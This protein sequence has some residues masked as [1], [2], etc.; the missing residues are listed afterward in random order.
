VKRSVANLHVKSGSVNVHRSEV[1]ERINFSNLERS[2]CRLFTMS[3][4]DERQRIFEIMSCCESSPVSIE[5]LTELSRKPSGF[6]TNKIRSK[7]WPKLL[8]INRYEIVDYKK[9]I[10]PHR[11]ERQ[12]R[13][14]I[15]RSFWS[16][17]CARHWGEKRLNRKRA[18]LSN[19]IIALLSNN[20][21]YYYFQG[22]HDVVS[23]FLLIFNDNPMAF[24]A[25]ESVCQRYLVDFMRRDFSS[26]SKMM[27]LIMFLIQFA[28]EELFKFLENSGTEPFFATSWLITWMSHDIR[29]PLH[30]F[31][32]SLSLMP[33][34]G[35][36][37]QIGRVF[38]VLLCSPPEY[39]FYLCASVGTLYFLFCL[40]PMT[41]PLLSFSL[42]FF[43][44]K[45]FS[46]SNVTSPQF[47][48]NSHGS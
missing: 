25:S 27:K 47:T 39:C 10:K 2:L 11:D 46:S 9:L 43:I 15:D 17:D 1:V 24:A 42:S 33:S 31:H 3:S 23:V 45:K 22:L 41:S 7:I 29:K 34:L 36:L 12:V 32:L 13:V 16:L 28:D 6:L 19:V 44:A 48:T 14:D 18:D 21:G 35:N 38:D 5:K 37:D 8:G 4:T 20:S 40:L 30:L 26:L